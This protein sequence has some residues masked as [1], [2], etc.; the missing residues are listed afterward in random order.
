MLFSIQIFFARSVIQKTVG[1]D[2]IVLV[3]NY[4]NAQVKGSGFSTDQDYSW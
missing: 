4:D 3:L 1:Q 2:V